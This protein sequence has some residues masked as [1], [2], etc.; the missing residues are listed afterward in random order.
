MVLKATSGN[1]EPEQPK[2]PVNAFLYE[3]FNNTKNGLAEEKNVLKFKDSSIRLWE[4]EWN[5]LSTE[6]NK[7]IA[8]RKC[9]QKE[10]PEN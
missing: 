7:N 4:D 2:F 6:L 9:V 5:H 3:H 10:N 1:T 8:A